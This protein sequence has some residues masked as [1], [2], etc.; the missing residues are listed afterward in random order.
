MGPYNLEFTDCLSVEPWQL[1]A[2]D[3]LVL[4]QQKEN[5]KIGMKEICTSLSFAENFRFGGHTNVFIRL[6]GTTIIGS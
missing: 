3:I 5:N 6:V 4:P 2:D 1:F